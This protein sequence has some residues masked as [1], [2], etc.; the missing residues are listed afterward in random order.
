MLLYGQLQ[1]GLL[2]CLM[3]SPAVSGAQNY[4]ELCVAAKREK[5]RLAELQRKQQ[6]LK[7]QNMQECGHTKKFPSPG[8]GSRRAY[9]SNVNHRHTENKPDNVEVRK[10]KPLRCYICDSPEHLARDCQKKRP[11]LRVNQQPH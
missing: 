10:A 3:E 8:I 1:E 9:R 11:R 7:A 4:K 2:Y 6:Y 5:R